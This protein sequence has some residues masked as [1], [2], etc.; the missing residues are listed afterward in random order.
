[1]AL[2]GG[3]VHVVEEAVEH[4]AEWT[5]SR[6][7]ALLESVE[8]SLPPLPPSREEL[9]EHGPAYAALAAGASL[10]ALLFWRCTAALWRLLFGRRRQQPA[11]Q[12]ASTRQ[13]VA[14]EDSVAAAAAVAAEPVVIPDADS[15]AALQRVTISGTSLNYA[16]TLW[17][18]TS[19]L[20]LFSSDLLNTVSSLRP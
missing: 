16:S 4:G 14:A 2:L 10:L 9:L 20:V 12:A 11:A 13:R 15:T 5:R 3:A 17:I 7:S 1:M 6:A 18:I 8:A 19:L